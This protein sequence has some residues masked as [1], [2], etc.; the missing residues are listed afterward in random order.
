MKTSIKIFYGS[1][2]SHAPSLQVLSS[3]SGSYPTIEEA[4]TSA[5][6]FLA[7]EGLEVLSIKHEFTAGLLSILIWYNMGE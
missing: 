1:L 6:E 5:N 3:M 4:E 2:V 7:K